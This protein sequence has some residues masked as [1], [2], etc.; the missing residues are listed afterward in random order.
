MCVC[1]CA[2]TCVVLLIDR[3]VCSLLDWHVS[4]LSGVFCKVLVVY[5]IGKWIAWLVNVWSAGPVGWIGEMAG[6]CG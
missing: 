1:A 4:G 3:L 5:C 6:S 2:C